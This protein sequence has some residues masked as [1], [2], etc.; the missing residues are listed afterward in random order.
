MQQVMTQTKLEKRVCAKVWQLSNPKLETTFSKTMFTMAM[1]L[2]FRKRQDANI[3]LPESLPVE[4]SLSAS[5][6]EVSQP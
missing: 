6:E 5:D 2:M 3:Q 4:L 1:H